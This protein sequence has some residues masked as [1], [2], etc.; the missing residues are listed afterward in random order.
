MQLY[1]YGGIIGKATDANNGVT[2]MYEFLLP[3]P[4]PSNLRIFYLE[5]SGTWVDSGN[6][7]YIAPVAHTVTATATP[8]PATTTWHDTVW[9]EYYANPTPAN[10]RYATW[11]GPSGDYIES[12][13]FRPE[14]TTRIVSLFREKGGGQNW[15]YV[16]LDYSD[17]KTQRCYVRK[18]EIDVPSDLPTIELSSVPAEI[19]NSVTPRLGPGR[20]YV[21]MEDAL[22]VGSRVTVL[23]EENGYLFIE[24]HCV[25]GL[26]RAWIPEMCID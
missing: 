26:A 25:S 18:S 13:S 10:I 22:R 21:S 8:M 23:H 20:G 16:E 19:T 6:D 15:V 7:L 5:A 1:R 12:G 2:W 17:G 4:A 3:D 14:K 11:T 24:Y 9:D